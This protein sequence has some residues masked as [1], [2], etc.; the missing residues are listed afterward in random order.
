MKSKTQKS[1]ELKKLKTKLPKSKITVFTTFSRAGE[2]GLSVAQ[3]SELKKALR[4]M[5]AEYFVTKKTLMDLVLKESNPPA[6]GEGVDVYNMEGS[7]GLVL[8]SGD[9]Y[10]ISKKLYEFAK[11]NK[12]LQFFG[13]IFESHFM[14]KEKF[15]E[16]AKMPSREILLAR[17]FGMMKYPVSGLAMVLSEI[18]KKKQVGA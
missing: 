16:M 6:G 7:V 9:V 17:L 4:T 11:K 5:D 10:A 15:L 3:M 2:K 1:T 13:A 8:G 18:V 14:D 12:A